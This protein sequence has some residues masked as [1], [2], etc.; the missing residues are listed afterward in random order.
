M[1]NETMPIWKPLLALLILATGLAGCDQ[2]PEKERF[3][4]TLIDKA[5]N[6]ET[7]KAGEA[8]LARNRARAGVIVT[9]SGLQI[10]HLRR[11]DGARPSERDTVVVHYQGTR[12]DGGVFDSSYARQ[13]PA[14]FP[15]NRVIRG[16]REGLLRMREGGEAIL[17]LPPELAYGATSPS[18]EIPANSTLI[19]RV[20]LIKV[21]EGEGAQ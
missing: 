10:E 8:F 9:D 6:D 3:R 16:W 20:E 13:E 21:I 11:G 1:E 14:T 19:F 4:Q 17:Y 18:A 7:R 12:V 2:D 5:L 15:L